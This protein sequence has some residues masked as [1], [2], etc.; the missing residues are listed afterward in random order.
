MNTYTVVHGRRSLQI[1]TNRLVIP[2]AEAPSFASAA[3]CAESLSTLLE[4][5]RSRVNAALKA[6]QQLGFAQGQK[7]SEEAAAQDLAQA[8]VKLTQE[9]KVQQNTVREA[10]SVLAL[11]VVNKV[12]ETLGAMQVVPWLIEQAVLEL[13]PARPTRIRVSPQVFEEARSH[14]SYAG[15][16]ADIRADENLS[17]FDCVIESDQGQ[18]VVS[19]DTQL[20]IIGETLGV[21]PPLDLELV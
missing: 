6:A 4:H 14:M 8:L 13:L 12:S 11:A 5:E 19:L 7:K 10:V 3:H 1:A 15:L 9:L 18:N 2:A 21:K 17:A 20:A 16:E